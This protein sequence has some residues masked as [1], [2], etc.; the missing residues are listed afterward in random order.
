MNGKPLA[1]EKIGKKRYQEP[2]LRVYG[3][4]RQLTGLVNNGGAKTDAMFGS[5]KSQ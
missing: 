1:S 4:V 5:S 2:R 3:D